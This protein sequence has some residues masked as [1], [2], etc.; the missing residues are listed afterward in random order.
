LRNLPFYSFLLRRL[1]NHLIFLWLLSASSPLLPALLVKNHLMEPIFSL[2]PPFPTFSAFWPWQRLATSPFTL[3][4]FSFS[5]AT[6]P[7]W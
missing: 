4:K 3:P 5:A 7:L 1:I 6:P 2:H